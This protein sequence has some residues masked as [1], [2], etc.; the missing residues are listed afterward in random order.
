MTKL[1]RLFTIFMLLMPV[2]AVTQNNRVYVM[3]G[4]GTTMIETSKNYN[5]TILYDSFWNFDSDFKYG[6]LYLKNGDS[7]DN[8]GI[9]YNITRDR[10]EVISNIREG[11]YIVNP[12][13]INRIK[14][15]REVFT[16][17]K[18]FNAGEKLSKG[19][20]KIVYD[21]NTKLFY[22]KSDKYKPGKG[23]A[24]G[25][26]A[27]KLFETDFYLKKAN[28]TL[29]ALIKKTKQSVLKQ[30]SDQ[31]KAIELFVNTNHLEYRK[32]KDLITILTYYDNL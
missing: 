13:A 16:Y 22:R 10:F 25:Y 2:I 32:T 17:S 28:D 18:F 30:L 21:G 19:Y 7:I 15:T 11:I 9:R 14:R 29:P 23:G 12:D 31:K 3:G 5:K 24:F 6:L 4:I 8:L 20:F 27:F 26:S 1:N